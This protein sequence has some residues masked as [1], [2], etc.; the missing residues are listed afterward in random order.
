MDRA[1][2]PALT[3][4]GFRPLRRAEY[5]R[6]VALGMFEDERIEL[7]RGLLVPM[8]P[9]GPRHSSTIDRL[10]RLLVMALSERA[11]VRVQNP[12]AATEDSE[13]EPDVCVVPL[14]DYDEAHP[15]RADLLIEV[16]ETSLRRDRGL[17]LG[18]YAENGVPEYWVVDLVER[19]IEVHSEPSGATYGRVTRFERGQGIRLVRFPD[20]EIRVDDVVPK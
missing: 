4:D 12:F 20:I 8:S 3:A 1:L 13:P 15:E 18:I 7:L 6:M 5:D 9:I 14:G 17:K 10:N 16:A 11:I 2:D 19:L